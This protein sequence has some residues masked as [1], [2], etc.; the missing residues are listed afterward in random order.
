MQTKHA[1]VAGASIGLLAGVAICLIIGT[2]LSDAL[3]RISVLVI[4]GA[5]M[6]V[7]LAWLNVLLSPKENGHLP[8]GHESRRS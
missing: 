1:A 3:F 2:S 5:W 6:G 7:L 4:G 8:N